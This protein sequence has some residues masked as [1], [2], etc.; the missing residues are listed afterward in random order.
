[1]DYSKEEIECEAYYKHSIQMALENKFSWTTLAS[2]FDQMS[3][4]LSQSKDLVK[5]LL[6]VIQNLQK[7]YQELVPHE[8]NVSNENNQLEGIEKL[9]KGSSLKPSDGFPIQDSV[10][11]EFVEETKEEVDQIEFVEI[12]DLHHEYKP[13]IEEHD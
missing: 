10:E 5:I 8:A 1:M 3:P 11:A 13:N 7:Q 6:D 4:T 2:V 9:K 12:E